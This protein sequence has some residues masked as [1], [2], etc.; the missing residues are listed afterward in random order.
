MVFALTP[1]RATA[2]ARAMDALRSRVAMG[3]LSAF[4]CGSVKLS[5]H[6]ILAAPPEP[7]NR[8]RGRYKRIDAGRT[9]D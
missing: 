5:L 1:A 9:G 3:R 2:L 7:V 6:A 8:R 4:V